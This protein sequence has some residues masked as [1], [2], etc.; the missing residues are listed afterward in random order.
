MSYKKPNAEKSVPQ[1]N[2]TTPMKIGDP[3]GGFAGFLRRAKASAAG[4]TA[5]VFGE[6]GDDSDM[7]TTLHLTKHLD[8]WVKVTIWMVKDRY[9]KITKKDG[10]Y[11]K[12]T[13]F[14]A[15]VKRPQ[16]SNF[17]QVAQFFGE[18][19]IN[20][21]AINV[22]NKSE[23]LDAL[24]YVEMHQ[25]AAGMTTSDFA[26]QKPGEELS[27]LGG[28]LTPTETADL[29]KLQKKS[30]EAWNLLK[31]QGFFR[32][33]LVISHLGRADDF[34]KWMTSQTCCH[35]G[36]KPCDNSP[37][38]AW[39]IPG[40]KKFACLPLC[41]EHEELWSQGS[42]QLI[43]GSSPATFI[44]TQ[45]IT[46]LQRWSQYALRQYLGTPSNHTPTPQSVFA[47][48][49]ERKIDGLLPNTFKMFLT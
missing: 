49:L 4:L 17:G 13:E 22:L 24:V 42:V 31:A 30:E 7:I 19:G 28:R 10:E 3:I 12:L 36:D 48:A 18:N 20:S 43:D 6:N 26:A 35:P 14:I 5:Q 27:E 46:Y 2:A 8:N 44:A 33:D 45:K 23:F 11:I 47:W 25:A 39:R 21:D 32:Y 37:V 1:E 34:E 16:A 29:K 9:G 40:E 15:T 41:S 38:H